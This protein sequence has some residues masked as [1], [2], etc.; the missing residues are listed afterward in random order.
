VKDGGLYRMAAEDIFE[1]LAD[2]TCG[3]SLVV[4]MFEIYGAVL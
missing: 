3:L 4:S 1:R 2:P